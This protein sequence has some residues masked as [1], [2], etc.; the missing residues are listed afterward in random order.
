M[1]LL[2]IINKAILEKARMP[3][4]PHMRNFECQSHCQLHCEIRDDPGLLRNDGTVG[5]ALFE[6]A[7]RALRAA[8]DSAPPS[9]PLHPSA[10]ASPK[11]APDGEFDSEYDAE[12]ARLDASAAAAALRAARLRELRD[13][14]LARAPAR[15]PPGAPTQATSPPSALPRSPSALPGGGDTFQFTHNSLQQSVGTCHGSTVNFT[16]PATTPTATGG[17]RTA[18]AAPT[19]AAGG[20]HVQP[21]PPDKGGGPRRCA[22]HAGCTDIWQASPAPKPGCDVTAANVVQGQDIT[23]APRPPGEDPTLTVTAAA[24]PTGPPESRPLPA[25]RAGAIHRWAKTGN[26]AAAQ[27]TR[28]SWAGAALANAEKEAPA[29]GRKGSPAGQLLRQWRV[30]RP[31]LGHVLSE[32]AKEALMNGLRRF[33]IREANLAWATADRHTRIVN[34]MTEQGGLKRYGLIPSEHYV[35]NNPHPGKGDSAL[36]IAIRASK[37]SRSSK[38]APACALRHVQSFLLRLESSPAAGGCCLSGA[39]AEPNPWASPWSTESA[40]WQ[41]ATTLWRSKDS[42]S[43]SDPDPDPDRDP[44][45]G[46]AS[47]SASDL[48]SDSDSGSGSGPDDD[49]HSQAGC[50]SV[51]YTENCNF[52]RGAM[53]HGQE[54]LK[55][56][57]KAKYARKKAALAAGNPKAAALHAA[58]AAFRSRKGRALKRDREQAAAAELEKFRAGEKEMEKAKEKEKKKGKKKESKKKKPKAAAKAKA[59]APEQG[60]G[61]RKKKKGPKGK[62]EKKKKRNPPVFYLSRSGEAT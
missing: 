45:P 5:R 40:A 46:S 41:P 7:R 13:T 49:N 29:L 12:I 31:G 25:S 34:K 60:G 39:V 53:P 32:G 26:W 27:L 9:L 50:T 17:A 48:D 18:E 62:E 14:A 1:G 38:G 8:M 4:I 3:Q 11:A 33:M 51:C 52:F 24:C 36:G 59:R 19:L 21:P 54:C 35:L 20:A 22:C 57:A 44:G 56:R 2:S 6:E 42:D 23:D 15:P 55:L 58:K 28:S 47:A 43:D 10:T 30:L 16:A 61:G 37:F